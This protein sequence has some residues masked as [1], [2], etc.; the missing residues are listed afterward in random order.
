MGKEKKYVSSSQKITCVYCKHTSDDWSELL[1]EGL[2]GEFT[3]SCP[4]CEK[5]NS[6][7]YSFSGPDF[8][9]YERMCD[10]CN[11][12]Q[13]G[14][15]EYLYSTI[16]PA[17]MAEIKSTAD[18]IIILKVEGATNKN[19]LLEKLWYEVGRQVW[20]FALREITK[21]EKEKKS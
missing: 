9:S 3:W 18:K 11:D 1:G 8:D 17:C 4:S 16:C 14:L 6:V 20:E 5:E 7:S 13:D 21:R 2:E 15:T 12:D 10:V 19:E